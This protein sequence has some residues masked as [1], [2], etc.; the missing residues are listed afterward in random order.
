MYTLEQITKTWQQ[1]YGEDMALEYKGFL[2]ALEGQ[3]LTTYEAEKERYEGGMYA[4]KTITS[5][6]KEVDFEIFAQVMSDGLA[7]EYTI[8]INQKEHD[9][10]FYN[11]P[12]DVDDIDKAASNLFDEM[13][14][15]E[16]DFFLKGANHA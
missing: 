15:G 4:Q 13:V 2:N 14:Q 5:N 16:I 8:F 12:L 11:M 10:G 1:V 3:N 7:I 6:N 9:G